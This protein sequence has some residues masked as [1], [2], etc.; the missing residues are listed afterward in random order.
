MHMYSNKIN[1]IRSIALILTFIGFL[2]MYGGIYFRHSPILMTILMTL[3]ILFIILSTV[4]Y[5]WIGLLSTKTI[6]VVCPGCG[7]Q[8]KMLG[9][10]DLCMHCDEPLTLDPNLAG[11]EFDENYNGKKRFK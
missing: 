9:K 8:T 3:G 6:K 5:F 4:V 10:V 2:V 1:K 11:K 7:K